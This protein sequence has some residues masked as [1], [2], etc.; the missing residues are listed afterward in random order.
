MKKRINLT[1]IL[2]IAI[3]V[4]VFSLVL[5]IFGNGKDNIPYS[6]IVQL[7]KNEQV[8]S[9][10]VEENTITL[11]LHSG[12]EGKMEL[13]TDLADPEGFRQDMWALLQEQSES[14]VLES[15]NFVPR[16]EQSPYSYILP[17]ILAGLVLI[18]VCGG[19]KRRFKASA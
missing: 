18:I 15:Y 12:F 11:R 7:F 3:L 4:L 10:V 16:E 13:K 5:N 14:G 6:Q 19:I 9:F 2:Y 8:K 17:I 1:P